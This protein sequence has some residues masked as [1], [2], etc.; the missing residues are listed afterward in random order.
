MYL[1][2][3]ELQGFKSFADKTVLEFGQGVT[4]VV[5]PNGS[6]KSNISDA[7]RWV[8]G[9][10]SAK[11]LRGGSMQDV[12]FS[13]TQKRKQVNY[14]EV[15]LVLDNSDHTFAVD[16]NEVIVTRRVFRSGE[17]AYQINRA[18]CRLRDIH[19]LFMDT[20]LGRDGYSIIGQGS[21]SQILSTKAEDRRSI[22]EEAAGIAKYKHRKDEAQHK[23]ANVQDNLVRIE[24]KTIELGKRVEPLRNQS[25]KARRYIE[26]YDEYKQLDIYMGL[27]KIEVCEDGVAEKEKQAVSVDEELAEVQGKLGETELRLSELEKETEKHDRRLDEINAQIREQNM[28]KS[29]IDGEIK[30]ANNDILHNGEQLGRIA[31]EIEEI[32]KSRAEW[33]SEI[34]ELDRQIKEKEREYSDLDAAVSDSEGADELQKQLDECESEL[35]DLRSKAFEMKNQAVADKEKK[36]GTERLR[37][38]FIE[39]REAVQIQLATHGDDLEQTSCEINSLR[40]EICDKN[41]RLEKIRIRAQKQETVLAEAEA[42]LDKCIKSLSA[43]RNEFQMKQSRKRMLEDMENAYEGYAR[44]VKTVLTAPKLK[45]LAIYGAL[46]GLIHVESEY[47][48]A[49]E[50]A[51][52]GA[53]QNIVVESEEDAKQAI[54]FLREEKAGRATFLPISAVKGRRLEQEKDAALM[55]GFVGIAC[56]L[57]H[58]DKKYGGIVD[59]LLG[60]VAVFDTIDNAIAASKRFNY[61]FKIVTLVGDVMN[62]GGSMSGGSAGR[63]AGFLSRANDIEVLGREMARLSAE[64]RQKEKEKETLE[65]DRS[66]AGKQLESYRP[67]IREYEDELLRLGGKQE[68]LQNSLSE[69]GVTEKS[70]REE[71]NELEAQL[72]ETGDIIAELINSI[73]RGEESSR[74]AEEQTKNLQE[75][76]DKL[77]KEREERQKANTDRIVNMR[78]LRQQINVVNDKISE[79]RRWIESGLEQIAGKNFEIE[80]VKLKTE[81]LESKISECTSRI[82][83]INEEEQ[84]LQAYTEAV[85]EEKRKIVEKQRDI[86]SSDKGLSDRRMQLTE[87]KMRIE[88]RIESLNTQKATIID[89]FWDKYEITYTA[90]TEMEINVAEQVRNEKYL[91]E[92]NGKIKALGHVNMDAIEEY[93][94][95]KEEFEF[96][97]EQKSDLEKSRVNLNDIISSMDELMKDNFS[98]QFRIINESFS[99]VFK[100]LFGGGRAKLYLSEPDNVLESGIEIEVQLPGK[101]LQNISLYSGGEKSFIA[102]ALLFAILNV[103]PTPFC[104]LDEI[105]AALDDVNVSR[106]A[107]Y[108]KHF[109]E[110]TQFIV[111]THRRGT[112]EA[113]NLMYGVTMQEKGV[114]KLLS[115]E[116]DDVDDSMVR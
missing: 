114:S 47:V 89:R 35:N 79:R 7:I 74:E 75:R 107:T 24:D 80:A 36:N 86:R 62:P 112:M 103:K 101:S 115:L 96:L 82:D 71:L 42:G 6:G 26:L 18:N 58:C 38:S 97:S 41:E 50:T 104:I 88:K 83:E 65:Q 91:G 116:I 21:V 109:L 73:R 33:N 54:T 92:L 70:L 78:G 15:S 57:V 2:R 55:T 85:R 52:G 1:K 87:E 23:L 111:I 16:F 56:D 11:Q 30:L 105:D 68:H 72:A 76:Y 12:I 31:R 93:V 60:R 98:S 22:F 27:R 28:R 17:T 81:E 95:V 32:E 13:G 94:A 43:M 110:Q 14:A 20:G 99:S 48:T 108:L 63:S 113:A 10:M 90:A 46:S 34:E 100:E 59:S 69:S 64:I 3:L 77:I 45:R 51:L 29:D 67:L 19:E 5:G 102:I 40:D 49:I 53:M 106:F 9:E 84:K 61:R 8:L 25:E 4:A 37:A 39:R 44:S 66:N